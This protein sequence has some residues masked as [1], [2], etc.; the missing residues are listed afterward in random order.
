MNLSYFRFYWSKEK[1]QNDPKKKYVS[2]ADEVAENGVTCTRN[3]WSIMSTNG[4]RI[5]LE[6]KGS[7]NDDAAL[8]AEWAQV[9][10][11]LASKQT[12]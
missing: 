6:I 5:D 12:M 1:G 9:A 11:A 4:K 3:R 2:L 7:Q 10:G 8:A